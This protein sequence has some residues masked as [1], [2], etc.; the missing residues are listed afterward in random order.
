[1]AYLF[2]AKKKNVNYSYLNNTTNK[3]KK[4]K[5]RTG[6]NT[7]SSTA[8]PQNKKKINK[9]SEKK[10]C[11]KKENFKEQHKILSLLSVGTERRNKVKKKKLKNFAT[12][13]RDLET[14]NI[15][16]IKQKF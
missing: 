11:Q 3:K 15:L 4:K 16:P 13:N 1:M 12:E 7:I 10:I 2:V 5:T 9:T 6:E 8:W 14:S